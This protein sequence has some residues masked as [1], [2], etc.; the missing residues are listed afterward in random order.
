ME[1]EKTATR[2]QIV[3]EARTWL[4][5]PFV[6]QG[7]L[8]GVGVDCIGLVICVARDLAIYD[9]DFNNYR[10][11]PN[12]RKMGDEL[13]KNLIPKKYEDLQMGDIIW[14]RIRSLPQHVG[15]KTDTGFIHA[16]SENKKVLEVDFTGKWID[17]VY[18]IFSYHG[19]SY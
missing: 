13:K 4:G 18:Q 16:Y 6:H 15:I 17:L 12:P 11:I 1:T 9:Y 2:Q 7:R 19:V 3:D 8:K 10:V 5:T 14:F